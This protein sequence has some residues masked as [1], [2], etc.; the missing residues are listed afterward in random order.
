LRFVKKERNRHFSYLLIALL[1]CLFPQE[2]KGEVAQNKETTRFSQAQLITGKNSIGSESDIFVGLEIVTKPGWKTYWRSPGITGYPPKLNWDQ[3]KNF[4]S[5]RIYWPKPHRFYV[6][7]IEAVGYLEKVL[8][9]IKITLKNP[10]EAFHLGLRVNYL[11]CDIGN[12][13]Q[14]KASFNL[15][16]PKGDGSISSENSLIETALKEVPHL[17]TGKGMTFERAILHAKSNEQIL[18]VIAHKADGFKHPELF[19]ESNNK[20]FFDLP[21]IALSKTATIAQFHI[22]VYENES[23]KKPP[24]ENLADK[25]IILTLVDGN[26]AVETQKIVEPEG[27]PF[28]GYLLI[29]LSAFIGGLILNFMP[30]VLPVLS[31]K[32][33]GIVKSVGKPKA[34]IRKEFFATV[35]GILSS[36]VILALIAI[37]LKELGHAVGWGLQFQQPIFLLAMIFIL[38]LI[39]C[40]LWGFYEITTP[41]F[42]SRFLSGIGLS[43]TGLE[44]HFFTGLLVTVLATPCTAPFLATALGFALSRGSLEILIIFMFMGLG[45]SSLYIIFMAFPQLIQ[46]LPKPGSW[47]VWLKNIFGGFLILTAGWLFISLTYL[48]GYVISALTAVLMLVVVLIL[49]QLSKIRHSKKLYVWMFVGAVGFTIT[50]LPYIIGA[51]NPHKHLEAPWQPFE[52]EKIARL[53]NEDKI[54]LVDVTADWCLTCKTN[55][56]FAFKREKVRKWLSNEKVVA[57]QADW[58]APNEA[59]EAYMKQFNVY[60]IPLTIVYGKNFPDGIKLPQILTPEIIKKFLNKASD[61]PI[62]ALQ[63][64]QS[65]N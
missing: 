12:C 48:K 32:V 27:K 37:L 62:I 21:Q 35:L 55:E 49:S 15:D 14:E 54:V 36:F 53:V 7:G 47:M 59:I 58:T 9:P 23:K 39:A 34:T 33:L 20:I 24:F 10:K 4:E 64:V 3:S 6:R 46:R 57:M 25:M 63:D 52:P 16:I 5:F 60:G 61:R 50:V 45:L 8:L 19:I 56:T 42:M 13:V 28:I 44:S 30:C 18:E 51:Q 41:A 31:L 65:A 26:Q 29:L 17:D 40:N 38:T 11:V 2:S 22:P 43:S 1:I